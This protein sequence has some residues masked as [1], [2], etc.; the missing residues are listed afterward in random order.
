MTGKTIKQIFR[1]LEEA[2]NMKE[3]INDGDLLCIRVYI[4]GIKEYEGRSWKDFIKHMKEEYVSEYVVEM[5]NQYFCGSNIIEF[6][7][8]NRQTEVEIYVY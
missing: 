3:S 4:E 7:V 2:N 1:A 8:N 5:C 6:M